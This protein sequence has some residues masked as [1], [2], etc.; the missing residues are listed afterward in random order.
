MISGMSVLDHR[1]GGTELTSDLD[2]QL[3]E[4]LCLSLCHS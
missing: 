3:A 1:K 4:L 2:Q